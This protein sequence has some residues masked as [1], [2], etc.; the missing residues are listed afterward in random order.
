VSE[1]EMDDGIQ[2]QGPES[3]QDF[4]H[5]ALKSCLE[6][7]MVLPF[8][9]C[10]VSPNGSSATVRFMKPGM[11][12][13]TLTKHIEGDRF[14]APLTIIILDQENNAVRIEVSGDGVSYH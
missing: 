12:M 11:P 6:D 13:E 7:G 3:L 9:V 1:D 4:L 8:V 10:V 14:E 5:D 2:V